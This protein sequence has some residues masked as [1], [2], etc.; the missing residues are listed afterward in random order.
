MSKT[1]ELV[2]LAA[3]APAAAQ[4]AAGMTVATLCL[5]AIGVAYCWWHKG[6]DWITAAIFMIVG[7]FAGVTAL[8]IAAKQGVV[9]GADGL[10]GAIMGL[11]V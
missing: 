11:F 10:V 3:Q 9:A 6:T 5:L 1:I 2:S 4:G 7:M 8:G